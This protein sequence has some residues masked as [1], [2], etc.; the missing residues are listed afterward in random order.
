M[1]VQKLTNKEDQSKPLD[2]LQTVPTTI[3]VELLEL[4]ARESLLITSLL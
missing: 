3:E 4:L 2:Y 1:V